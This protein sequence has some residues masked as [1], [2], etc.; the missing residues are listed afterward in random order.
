M[1][2]AYSFAAKLRCV[3]C[4]A[5]ATSTALELVDQREGWRC[6][7]EIACRRR[8]STVVNLRQSIEAEQLRLFEAA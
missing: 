5:P 3:H 4:G 1:S 8:K 6:E 7:D 2:R